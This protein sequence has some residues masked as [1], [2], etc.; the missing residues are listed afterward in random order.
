MQ[1]FQ[2]RID[3]GAWDAKTVL[4]AT[5]V[6]F[7][8]VTAALSL[9]LHRYPP[10][11]PDE[12][13]AKTFMERV[14]HGKK[15][16]IPEPLNREL[17]NVIHPR[18][19]TVI[20]STIVPQGFPMQMAFWG[21]LTRITRIPLPL[22]TPFF[23]ALAL[24]LLFFL[25]RFFFEQRLALYA[26]LL[27]FAHPAVLYYTIH[28]FYPNA[29]QVYFLITALALGAW[30]RRWSALGSG[31]LLALAVALRPSEIFWIAPVVLLLAWRGRENISRRDIIM[32]SSGAF[33]ILGLTLLLHIRVYGLSLIGYG[34]PSGDE[35]APVIGFSVARTIKH[36]WQY[37]F[38]LFWWW[39][40]LVVLGVFTA[41]TARHNGEK[42]T[43]DGLRPYCFLVGMVALVIIG[44]YGSWE[45]KDSL[46]AASSTI[47][48]S[49][50][51]YWFVLYVLILPFAAIGL[52]RMRLSSGVIMLVISVSVLYPTVLGFESVRDTLQ[53]GRTSAMLQ[54]R[55]REMIPPDAV[56]LVERT[57]KIF[58]PNWRVIVGSPE[59]AKALRLL[60]EV[61]KHVPLYY[62][63]A[64]DLEFASPW[65]E[66]HLNR[67]GLTFDAP[68]LLDSE[69]ALIPIVVKTTP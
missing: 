46:S 22:W 24:P 53:Y 13:A 14:A 35:S 6:V 56:I 33:I 43:N 4:I 57:D 63:R 16:D 34:L 38:A 62:H 64:S 1:N 68:I 19:T 27:A 2:W 18:S 67:V 15:I 69:N 23:G 66:T 12:T 59:R 49:F 58:W 60:P 55:A 61:R 41:F 39:T 45:I 28:G 48:T 54:K 8:V 52:Q 21:I 11:S 37:L 7:F 50:V 47:G 5:A 40:P 3:R 26:T 65:D 31:A 42:L 17:E 10:S 44:M 29:A 32:V 30:Q 51:R 9:A 20:G 25:F 36:A